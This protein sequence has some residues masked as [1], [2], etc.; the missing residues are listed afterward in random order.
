MFSHENMHWMKKIKKNIDE[1]KTLI[2]YETNIP[3]EIGCTWVYSVTAEEVLKEKKFYRSREELLRDLRF[4]QAEEY[5]K[6]EQFWRD[7]TLINKLLSESML[8]STLF[9]KNFLEKK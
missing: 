7:K 3:G 4:Q 6:E 9:L 1:P 8:K 5:F 2:W